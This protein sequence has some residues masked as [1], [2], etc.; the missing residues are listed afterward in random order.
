MIPLKD[1]T[2]VVIDL[3]TLD[4]VPTADYSDQLVTGE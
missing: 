4:T 2:H 3:E 1:H